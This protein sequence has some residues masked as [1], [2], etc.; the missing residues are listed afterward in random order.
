MTNIRSTHK[1][2]NKQI[3]RHNKKTGLNRSQILIKENNTC[4]NSCT[5]KLNNKKQSI[6]KNKLEHI[7]QEYIF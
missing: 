3:N 6:I 2:Q 7:T 5:Y 4:K 1:G